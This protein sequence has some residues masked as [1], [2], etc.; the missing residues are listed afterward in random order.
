MHLSPSTYYINHSSKYSIYFTQMGMQSHKKR[1]ASEEISADETPKPTSSLAPTAPSTVLPTHVY[2]VWGLIGDPCELL[3]GGYS[4]DE[5]S[6]HGIYTNCDTANEAAHAFYNDTSPWGSITIPAVIEREEA[7]RVFEYD[8]EP[9]KG[10][11]DEAGITRLRSDGG[12]RFGTTQLE[13]ECYVVWVERTVL[14]PSS[15]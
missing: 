10:L 15:I 14:N 12:L 7:S 13:D 5:Y 11:E 1:K 4:K 8:E 9:N 2:V 3:L 6:L